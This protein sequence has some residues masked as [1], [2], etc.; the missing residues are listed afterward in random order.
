MG[1]TLQEFLAMHAAGAFAGDERPEVR[2]LLD[3]LATGHWRVG[4]AGRTLT[5]VPP[6]ARRPVVLP[7]SRTAS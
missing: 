5:A 6:S 2:A 1:L 7:R 4:P 3:L